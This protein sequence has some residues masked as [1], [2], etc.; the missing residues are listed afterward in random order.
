VYFEHFH[1]VY[2]VM[3]LTNNSYTFTTCCHR[4]GTTISCWETKNFGVRRRLFGL[5]LFK[6]DH[7]V[8]FLTIFFV[9]YKSGQ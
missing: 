5:S 3:Y 1:V 6:T 2:R 8:D 7:F 4:W 9:K